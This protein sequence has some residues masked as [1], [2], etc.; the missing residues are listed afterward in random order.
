[1][2]YLKLV[3]LML[4]FLA[5]QTNILAAGVQD[6]KANEIDQ[7]IKTYGKETVL[8]AVIKGDENPFTIKIN[9]QLLQ[10][11]YSLAATNYDLIDSDTI[12]HD[13]EKNSVSITVLKDRLKDR[14]TLEMKEKIEAEKKTEQEN[15]RIKEEQEIL[16]ANAL[17]QERF[18][19]E[20][21]LAQEEQRAKEEKEPLVLI[22]EWRDYVNSSW[23]CSIK[24]YSK[25]ECF[26]I[27]ACADGSKAKTT[28]QKT[29][30]NEFASINNGFGEHYLIKNNGDLALY[31]RN[32]Y[33]R[34]AKKVE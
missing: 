22:G 16:K 15:L 17:A 3:F 18:D 2:K 33:I 31:D 30:P 20:N 34:T 4:T 19:Q 23:D 26:M 27:N 1:M 24:I 8:N 6:D 10:S 5:I 25:N 21:A 28:L 11:E 7:L 12:K 29:A 13:M 9:N 14:T 32:G